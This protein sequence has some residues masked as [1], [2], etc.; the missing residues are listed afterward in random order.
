MDHFHAEVTEN[1]YFIP[2]RGACFYGRKKLEQA[3]SYLISQLQTDWHGYEAMDPDE[4]HA[5]MVRDIQDYDG[6][7]EA[8]EVTEEIPGSRPGYKVVMAYR[9]MS[10]DGPC[11]ETTDAKHEEMDRESARWMSG[12]PK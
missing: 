7:S 10:I 3:K 1:S 2:H 9:I 4:H 11:E 12:H 5:Q 6:R 8:V